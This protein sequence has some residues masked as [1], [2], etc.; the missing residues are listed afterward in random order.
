MSKNKVFLPNKPAPVSTINDDLTRKISRKRNVEL[1]K[2]KQ[3][4]K[5]KSQK[6]TP[7]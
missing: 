7:K 6:Q 3:L 4:R 2:I 1:L 5:K